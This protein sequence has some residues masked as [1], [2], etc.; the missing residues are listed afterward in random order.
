[1]RR[2]THD[3][4]AMFGLYGGTFAVSILAGLVPLV[5]AELFLVWLVHFIVDRSS[6]LP[7]IVIAAAIGQMIAKIGL[8]HAGRGMLELPRGRYKGRYTAKLEAVR[9]KLDSW[10]TKPYLVYGV[11]SVTGLPP[12]YLTVLAAGAMKIRFNAFLAIGLA[13]RLLRFACLVAITWAA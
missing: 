11:S 3:L 13:G 9:Q 6:Q 8:Y 2:V 7:A 5:N 10:K 4:V 12:F 1:V